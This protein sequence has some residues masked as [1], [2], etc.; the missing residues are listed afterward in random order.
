[1]RV[2]YVVGNLGA[3]GLERFVTRVSLHAKADGRI[4]PSILCLSESGGLFREELDRSGVPIFEAPAGWR[5]S[6]SGIRSLGEIMRK[7][8]ADVVHSQVNFSLW[9]QF[10]AV[11]RSG[12][13]AFCV[14]ERN[15]YPLQ[16]WARARRM[17]QFHALRRFGARYTANGKAVAAHL[18]RLVRVPAASIGVLPNGVPIPAAR[19][20]VRESIRRDLGWDDRMLGIGYVSRMA[21]HKGHALF[22]EA[23]RGARQSGARVRACLIGD[24]PEKPAIA[25]LIKRC[26]LESDVALTGIVSNVDEYLEAFDA[27]ALLSSREGMPNALLEAMAAGK[28]IIA[29]DVGANAEILADG[30]AGIVLP[31]PDVG[32][33]AREIQKLAACPE[34]ALAIG[35]AARTRAAAVYSVE[36]CYGRLLSHYEEALQN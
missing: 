36:A 17:A 21:E 25:E 9:Q 1:M 7:A 23:L 16:G 18:A 3:G 31:A 26:D 6:K 8:E 24:G 22:L 15:C 10:S 30:E 32:L 28:P 12:A 5:R 14:T 20:R 13:R 19:P 29:T 2:L 34:Q 35:E 27:V 4:E 33:V 11:R